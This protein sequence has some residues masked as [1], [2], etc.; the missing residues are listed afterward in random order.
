M[1]DSTKIIIDLDISSSR[2]SENPNTLLSFGIDATA[3]ISLPGISA[4]VDRFGAMIEIQL[5]K[6]GDGDLGALSF[7]PIPKPPRGMAA[8]IT[9]PPVSGGGY[10]A[11][12][13]ES[14][15]E[16]RGSFAANLGVISV[17]ALA[18]IGL[19][20]FSTLLLMAAEFN[21]P[22][23][24]SFGFTLVGVGGIV[25]INRHA[26]EDALTDA[27][28]AG[29]LS[30]LLFPRDPVVEAPHLLD[31]ASR[32]FPYKDGGVLVGPMVK[33]GWGTPTM[34]SATLAIILST[35]DAKAIILG[36]IAVTLPSESAPLIYLQ[37]LIKGDIDQSG[38]R[39]DATLRNSRIIFMPVD[40]DIRLRMITGPDPLF[41]LSAGGFYPGYAAPEGMTGMRRLSV[42]LS[43]NP[44]MQLR[45]EAYLAITTTAL[46]FGAVVELIAGI[47]GYGI[48]GHAHF[49]AFI[50]Y[51]P[52][53]FEADLTGE[54]SVECA[55]FDV[56]S[57]SLSGV[58]S[59]PAKWRINGHASISIL[60]F[61][62]DI[63][64]PSLSWGPEAVRASALDPLCVL[65]EALKEPSN[66]AVT[67][68]EVPPIV[69]LR[70]GAGEDTLFHP[71][72]GVSFRQH[73][74]PI[75][76]ELALVDGVTLPKPVTLSVNLDK[77]ELRLVMDKFIPDRFLRIE[78]N[79]RLSR[80]GYVDLPCGLDIGS[81]ASMQG[82]ESSCPCT[83][84][85][86][87]LRNDRLIMAKLNRDDFFSSVIIGEH[88]RPVHKFEQL[89]TVLDPGIAVQPGA[90]I[91][92]TDA[93]GRALT[94]IAQWELQA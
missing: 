92:L 59:G 8:E 91:G 36:R 6:G 54:V 10:L 19:D 22:L 69:R 62:V 70:G 73:R 47:D 15:K 88:L 94:A 7:N 33:M 2:P 28:S 45:A 42:D 48:H 86:R 90:T 81:A 20:Q 24:L 14:N 53:T 4:T 17:N 60:F 9:V 77:I 63:D 84:E 32:C 12:Y 31:V 39:I 87:E 75:A 1:S 44:L 68:A 56:A 72:S 83:Y 18:V 27:L 76:T 82:L 85:I 46:Q 65:Q 3:S 64:L 78:G 13:G 5:K 21:P 49:D 25:G 43:P 93:A 67:S 80:S 35:A 16:L 34:M 38:V 26:N 79:D 57:I 74:I 58:F 37:A 89:I 29:D 50:Q 11:Q 30:R 23:Q 40:G 41:V 66:W 51:D 71:L 55:D 52:F 61:D